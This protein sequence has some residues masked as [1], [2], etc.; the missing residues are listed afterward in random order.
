M[1]QKKRGLHKLPHTQIVRSA[2]IRLASRQ[3]FNHFF[4]IDQG[5]KASAARNLTN[6]APPGRRRQAID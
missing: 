5:K 3:F 2:T 4:Q 1:T 6:F